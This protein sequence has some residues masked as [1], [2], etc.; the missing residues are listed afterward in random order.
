MF[1]IFKMNVR[2]FPRT[3]L[4]LCVAIIGEVIID[5]RRGT[6]DDLY[7]TLAV[8]GVI[9]LAFGIDLLV[10]KFRTTEVEGCNDPECSMC[11]LKN[12]EGQDVA[13]YAI[14]LAV[15]LAITL[16]VIH[17]IGSAAGNVMSSVGSQI[18]GS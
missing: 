9:G 17:L 6:K 14:M 4:I 7:L 8:L 13:E 16:G 11:S 3:F 15:I 18:A 2:R 10:L 5:I 12:D 1:A